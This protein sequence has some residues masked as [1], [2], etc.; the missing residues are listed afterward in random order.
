MSRYK[1]SWIG[2]LPEAFLDY[3]GER[4][5][6]EVEAII[7]DTVGMSRGKAMPSHKF[8][9]E[10]TF[11]LPISLFYQTI[12]GEYVDMDIEDQWL[13]KDIVLRPDMAT[14]TAVPWAD[15]PT[16][17]VIC[18]LE[19]R[20]G[21]PLGIAPR[22]VLKRVLG[23]YA[24]KGWRPVVAP[25]LEFYLTKPNTDPNEPIEP[26]LGRTG[27][28]GASR[29]AY[30]MVAVDEY[31]EVIDTIYDF[32]EA[33][34]LEIDTVIQE[35]GAG[36]IE[37]NLL[38]GDPLRQADQVFYFKRT[39]R[40]AAL[41]NGVFATFMAKPMRDEP[42]SAMH[43]HQSVVDRDGRN[44]FAASDGSETEAF[45][46]FIGGSQH[47][48][49]SVVPLLAPYVNSFRRFYSEGMS[50]PTNLEWGKD[51]RT[52]GLRIPNSNPEARRVENRVI[53]I[54]CNPYLAI[55]ASLASGYLGIVNR[56]EPREI[57]LHEVYE[58]E[59]N[60]PGG[61]APALDLFD[62]DHEV[63]DLLG[64]DFCHIYSGIK[65]AE[66]DEYKREISPWERQH[67]LLNA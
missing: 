5:L 31:G 63:R 46:H 28:K 4:R 44:I 29:Q 14:A 38:H 32:A 19:T 50:A 35:G 42:G 6:E 8:N 45:R 24:D 23:F 18:D 49:M 15:D 20:D 53:G 66:H 55:A 54:D 37:I 62:D 21:E 10:E 27:R 60:L 67:L 61:L 36:Q 48:L 39:I 13:E 51:N 59:T 7:P 2:H 65:H 40:E 22:N 58:T 25:E 57:A 47:Y 17:Q 34:G 41:K 9:P 16:L 64:R 1:N 43:I 56:V 3:L 26:P 11:F 52:T 12:S 30:S 33:Q